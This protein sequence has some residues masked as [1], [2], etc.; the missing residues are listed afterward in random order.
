MTH[1]G[2]S[3][4]VVKTSYLDNSTV[5]VALSGKA[6]VYP[7]PDA[8]Y[9]FSVYVDQ[10]SSDNVDDF[11]VMFA[12]NKDVMNSSNALNLE[13]KHLFVKLTFNIKYASE[14]SDE[15][16]TFAFASFN[17]D[18]SLN[19]KVAISGVQDGTPSM[20]Y[21]AT[22]D[23]VV[24]TNIKYGDADDDTDDKI[25]VIVG[26]GTVP[27]REEFLWLYKK[28]D[29]T[30]ENPLIV[31]TPASGLEFEKGKHYTFNLKVGKD[32]VTLTQVTASE[33]LPGWSNDNETDLN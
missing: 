14:Y 33:D 23:H 13:F 24:Q 25:E 2:T 29:Y 7:N 8:D 18:G 5:A 27:A 21:S 28:D 30:F 12:Y 26:D 3:W 6:E 22:D 10:T 9:E 17:F 32:K 11:D 16:P 4:N 31:K 15:P 20:E 1:D 19:D